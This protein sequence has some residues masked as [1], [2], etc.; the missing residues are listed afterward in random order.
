MNGSYEN[1]IVGIEG[2]CKGIYFGC[3]IFQSENGNSTKIQIHRTRDIGLPGN[4]YVAVSFSSIIVICHVLNDS[5]YKFLF[6]I[7]ILSDILF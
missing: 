5:F 1:T 3:S 6:I 4:W 2:P 7:M